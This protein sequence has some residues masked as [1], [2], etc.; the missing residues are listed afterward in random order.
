MSDLPN[1]GRDVF[2]YTRYLSDPDKFAPPERFLV[3][4]DSDQGAADAIAKAL[5]FT[6]NDDRQI[7]INTTPVPKSILANEGMV[8]GQVKR[9]R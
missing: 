4:V 5:E 8:G 7:W 9:V 2:V 1:H 3:A 6:P